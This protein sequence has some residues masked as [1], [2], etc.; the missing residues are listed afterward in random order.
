MT[1]VIRPGKNDSLGRDMHRR[2]AAFT[3]QVETARNTSAQIATQSSLSYIKRKRPVAPPRL[4]RNQEHIK[5]VIKWRPVPSLPSGVGL[6]VT[7]L[8]NRAKHWIIQEIGTGSRATVKVAG[9]PNPKGRPTVGSAYVKTVKS[10]VGR[11][12]SNALVF[13]TGPGG[14]WV[15]PKKG[16]TNQ[17]LYLRS[18]IKKVPYTNNRSQPGII[19]GKEIDG[20]HFVRLGGHT[21]FREY[22]RSVYAAAR[23][24]FRRNR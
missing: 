5:D 11:R 14:K 12:V 8:N 3:A 4:G 2:V 19:I 18:N 22:R 15:K 7:E 9:R 17:Q 23:Q 13:A 1:V 6:N 24:Q 21:G 20:Q 16:A 10:Q